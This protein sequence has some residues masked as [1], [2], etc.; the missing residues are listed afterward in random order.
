MWYRGL[1]SA[2]SG[3]SLMAAFDNG[4]IEYLGSTTTVLMYSNAYLSVVTYIVCHP[5]ESNLYLATDL[6]L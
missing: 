4:D 1:L 2:A 5:Y 3:S 6:I